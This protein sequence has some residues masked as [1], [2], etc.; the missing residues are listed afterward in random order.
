MYNTLLYVISNPNFPLVFEVL[1]NLDLPSLTSP[2]FPN[3]KIKSPSFINSNSGLLS[4]IYTS[5][6]YPHQGDSLTC[7]PILELLPFSYPATPITA[8]IHFTAC[9]NIFSKHIIKIV[10]SVYSLVLVFH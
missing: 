1:H 3:S 8:S 10:F 9:L 7:C 2:I 5:Y 6:T 4:V